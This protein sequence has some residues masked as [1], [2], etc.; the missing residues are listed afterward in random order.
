MAKQVSP[1]VKLKGTIDDLSF[2]ETQD[3]FLARQ[4]GGISAERIRTEP[5]FLRTRLNGQEFSTGAKAG[6]TF[7]LAFST[8][9]SKAADNRM[10]SRLNKLMVAILQTDPVNDFG[11]RQVQQ[12]DLSKLLHFNFNLNVPFQQ[13][14]ALPV[15]TNVDRTT[16]QVAITLPA[17]TPVTDIVAPEGTSHYNFFAAATAID[18]EAGT[19]TTARQTTP[20]LPWDSAEMPAS[21]ITLALPVNSPLPIMVALG[22]EFVKIVNGKVYP[23][24][25]GQSPLH[26][27]AVNAG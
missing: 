23:S 20:N 10:G 24:S 17:L 3:G 27:V 19:S 2:Y 15:T 18:F 22:M 9:I 26:L 21:T 1:I 11:K 16:G 7:R 12:G 4:K 13:V 8:E 14:L 5:N 6:R 25:K